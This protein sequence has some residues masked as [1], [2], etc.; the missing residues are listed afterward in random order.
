MAVAAGFEPAVGGYPTN[1]FEAFTF[2]RSDT[3]PPIRIEQTALCIQIWGGHGRINGESGAVSEPPEAKTGWTAGL[4][5]RICEVQGECAIF[6]NSRPKQAP[7]RPLFAKIAPNPGDQRSPAPGGWE[8]NRGI[9]AAVGTH[10]RPPTA[11][12]NQPRIQPS[13]KTTQYPTQPSHPAVA[14]HKKPPAAGSTQCT[15]RE[16]AEIRPQ[17]LTGRDHSNIE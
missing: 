4:A 15:T 7:N 3:P 16:R 1:A 14:K 8:P 12:Q 17:K 6:T 5:G 13:P 10:L 9:S 2:G 11:H